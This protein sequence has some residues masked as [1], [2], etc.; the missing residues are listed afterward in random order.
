MHEFHIKFKCHFVQ[1]NA[2]YE[3]LGS[4]NFIEIDMRN[5]NFELLTIIKFLLY[6]FVIRIL[7]NDLIV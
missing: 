7:N 5:V 4:N 1:Q 2:K 3:I 6:R